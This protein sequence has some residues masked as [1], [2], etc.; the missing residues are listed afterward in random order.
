MAVALTDAVAAK[1][2]A[3]Y[4]GL[5]VG[6]VNAGSRDWTWQ[7]LIN[8]VGTVEFGAADDNTMVASWHLP[9]QTVVTANH[10]GRVSCDLAGGGCGL[11]DIG[12]QQNWPAPLWAVQPMSSQT[13]GQATVL[14]WPGADDA[15][16]WLAAAQNGLVAVEQADLGPLASHWDGALLVELPKD[17]G[18]FL[19]L[20]GQTTMA[21]YST[22]GAVS[23]GHGI[24]QSGV[25]SVQVVV[26]PSMI[27]TLAPADRQLLITH[28]T[29][30]VAT[31]GWVIAPGF[32]WVSEGLAEN[33]A[34]AADAAAADNEAVLAK[35]ACQTSGITPPTDDVFAGSDATAQTQAYAVAQVLVGLVRQHLGAAAP[36]A[37]LKL[38]QD[39]DSSG[40]DLATWSTQWCS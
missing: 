15:V 17:T 33:V 31:T 29:V 8:L 9:G 25:G 36:A 19:H 27:A 23:L 28:E 39:G 4:D 35:A 13:D 1:D 11:D 34:V 40:I 32:T 18:A 12:P 30:H 10:V 38:G 7:N 2:K 22:T 24:G 37:L 3:A 26:N 21:G 16:D 5:F 6:Q 20:L 14:A